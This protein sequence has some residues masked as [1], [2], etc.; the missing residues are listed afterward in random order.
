MAIAFRKRTSILIET[1]VKI[2]TEMHPISLRGLHYQ[3]VVRQFYE[4]IRNNYQRL[5]RA[6]TKAREQGI[7]PWSWLVDSLRAT[8]KP[9]S[10]SG[11]A[12]FGDTVRTAYRK[13]YWARMPA[14][15]EFFVEKDA[16]A[17][18]LQPVTMKYDVPLNVIRGYCSASFAHTIADQWAQIDK[19]IFAYYLG[20]FDP[21]GFDIERDL[22]KK[23]TRYSGLRDGTDFHWQRLAVNAADF[24]EFDLAPMLAKRTDSRHKK[25]VAEHGHDC[26]E[27]DA[28]PPTV[29]R[30]RIEEAILSH[31]DSAEWKRLQK[32]EK[33]ELVS[34]GELVAGLKEHGD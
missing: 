32:I 6:T 20:D 18:A 23:L 5:S 10:W 21:S 15:A 30:E 14:Y 31:V 12:D 16:M 27:L 4:N 11:L 7:I 33:A 24:Q 9:S 29:L 28:I 19:P 34:I 8:I 25:F 13:D 2:L 1:A 3:L 17:A 26:A 22:R